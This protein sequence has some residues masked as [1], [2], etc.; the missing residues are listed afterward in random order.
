MQQQD[1]CQHAVHLKRLYLAVR[2]SWL[3]DGSETDQVKQSELPARVL[4]THCHHYLVQ[5][6]KS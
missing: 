4:Q 3:A 5:A 1:S 2:Y 6:P